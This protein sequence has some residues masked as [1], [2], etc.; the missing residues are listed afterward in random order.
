[1]D[2]II[3]IH[4]KIHDLIQEKKLQAYYFI[5][6]VNALYLSDGR[7][8]GYYKNIQNFKKQITN[9]T[10][11]WDMS[12]VNNLTSYPVGYI[13]LD[14]YHAN[15]NFISKKVLN[16]IYE[17]EIDSSFAV[18]ITKDNVDKVLKKQNELIDEYIEKNKQT[19]NS[20][21]KRES[22]DSTQKLYLKDYPKELQDL[23]YQNLN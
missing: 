22:Y 3:L 15:S 11:Y 18:Y 1:M 20:R 23:Y 10:P 6:P 8:M 7:D 4:S 21:N 12:F 9:I 19:V 5:P 17:K 14:V 13:F 16:T 2:A